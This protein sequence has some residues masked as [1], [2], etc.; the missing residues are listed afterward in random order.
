MHIGFDPEAKDSYDDKPSFVA[1]KLIR[2]KLHLS[3]ASPSSIYLHLVYL[4]CDDTSCPDDPK[5]LFFA[6]CA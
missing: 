4:S 3:D 5:V 1:K 2:V 6:C